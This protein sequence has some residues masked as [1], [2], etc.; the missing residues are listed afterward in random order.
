[1]EHNYKHYNTHPYRKFFDT[2]EDLV[3]YLENE[4][5]VI[6]KQVQVKWVA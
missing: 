5:L 2:T 4:S 6:N 1:M 3:R